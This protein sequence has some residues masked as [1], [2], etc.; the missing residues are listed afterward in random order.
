[1]LDYTLDELDRRLDPDAFFRLNRQY[2]TSFLAVRS[3]HN[4]FNGKLKVYVD[5]EVPSGII[6]S[7]NRANQFKQW[8]NR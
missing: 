5:P 4:Y 6:V 7:K 2:I 1:M 3:V 8:L